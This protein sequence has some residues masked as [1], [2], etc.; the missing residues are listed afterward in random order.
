MFKRSCE[1]VKKIHITQALYASHAWWVHNFP[2]WQ[3]SKFWLNMVSF[4][5]L[6]EIYF[7]VNI[8]QIM[9]NFS[10]VQWNKYFH[11][12]K[13]EMFYSTWLRL[14]EWNISF[15][16]IVHL[17]HYAHKYSL[18]HLVYDP[19]LT[20]SAPVRTPP[21]GDHRKLDQAS[22]FWG[23]TLTES[24]NLS[25]VSELLVLKEESHY[26]YTTTNLWE[27]KACFSSRCKFIPEILG[28][29]CLIPRQKIPQPAS[30]RN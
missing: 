8:K 22:H 9:N 7:A 6:K 4:V 20:S 1:C 3:R 5:L 16:T 29:K 28:K 27:W 24:T 13:D 17:Y 10:F 30:T 23:S 14:V 15:F 21:S 2:R 11:S 25:K 26:I 12:V 18:F 19:L